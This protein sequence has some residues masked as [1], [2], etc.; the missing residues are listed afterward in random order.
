MA[1]NGFEVLCSQPSCHNLAL[2]ANVNSIIKGVL[3]KENVECAGC[4]LSMYIK[5]RS[6]VWCVGDRGETGYGVVS[7]TVWSVPTHRI[8]TKQNQFDRLRVEPLLCPWARRPFV[9]HRENRAVYCRT[10]YINHH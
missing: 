9:D 5:R 10:T 1:E 6:V 8:G 7:G 4:S 3:L 2:L